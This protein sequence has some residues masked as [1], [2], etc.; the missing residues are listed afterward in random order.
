[1]TITAKVLLYLGGF[2]STLMLLMA[3]VCT[4]KS[5]DDCKKQCNIVI[6]KYKNAVNS[7]DRCNAFITASLIIFIVTM[8]YIFIYG[9]NHYGFYD[10]ITDSNRGK[11][12]F[13]VLIGA[14]SAIIFTNFY[15]K[16]QLF[17]GN[18]SN[19]HANKFSPIHIRY[20]ITESVLIIG[21][22]FG[23]YAFFGMNP[24]IKTDYFSFELSGSALPQISSTPYEVMAEEIKIDDFRLFAQ[25]LPCSIQGDIAFFELTGDTDAKRIIENAWSI[26]GQII[27]LIERSNDA[28]QAGESKARIAEIIY[29]VKRSLIKLLDKNGAVTDDETKKLIEKINEA[30]KG[31]HRTA[32]LPEKTG[33]ID[34]EGYNNYNYIHIPYKKP[35]DKPSVGW[36]DEL[37][38]KITKISEN[39][40]KN[41]NGLGS[42]FDNL[43]KMPYIYILSSL[44]MWNDNNVNGAID[45]LEKSQKKG[46]YINEDINILKLLT[47]LSSSYLMPESFELEYQSKIMEKLE[48]N[49]KMLSIEKTESPTKRALRQRYDKALISTKNDVA[50]LTIRKQEIITD[51]EIDTALQ[52]ANDAYEYDKN[53]P[54]YLDTLGY[55][56]MVATLRGRWDGDVEKQKHELEAARRLLAKAHDISEKRYEGPKDTAAFRLVKFTEN[57]LK[58]ADKYSAQI[59]Q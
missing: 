5:N 8:V 30:K 53:N 51:K 16:I 44:I 27:Y 25:G 55:V 28:Q 7:L 35:D 41:F 23:I 15:N 14:I 42:E 29:P 3:G 26:L 6:K 39:E 4:C 21:I 33:L 31:V 43:K 13:Y 50:Y 18:S 17:W 57:H 37:P 56:R 38:N 54:A 36:C 10:I 47:A 49:L 2:I 12:V 32:R 1:M 19:L 46:K 24:S 20:L 59:N 11:A 22:F 52:F 45:L 40:I 58:D 34:L 9:S 48:S